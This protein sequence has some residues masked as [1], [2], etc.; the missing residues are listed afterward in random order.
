MKPTISALVTVL[1]F[2]SGVYAANSGSSRES[3]FAREKLSLQANGVVVACKD[4]GKTCGSFSNPPVRREIVLAEIETGLHGEISF[5]IFDFTRIYKST[6]TVAVTKTKS[7]FDGAV[8][9]G[10]RVFTKDTSGNLKSAY[11]VYKLKSLAEMN[12]VS[13]VSAPIFTNAA[14]EEYYPMIV[15]GP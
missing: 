14:G 8:Y 9:Y 15:I 10:V 5:E 6:I 2:A 13:V 3:T 7:P 11:Q 12:T 1:L 4:S